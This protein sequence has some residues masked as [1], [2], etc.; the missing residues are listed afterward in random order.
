MYTDFHERFL[1]K[2]TAMDMLS[3]FA[4]FIDRDQ[5][6]IVTGEQL[7]IDASRRRSVVHSLLENDFLEATPM[8]QDGYIVTNKAF[9]DC[10]QAPYEGE[11]NI[12]TPDK[13][14]AKWLSGPMM[15]R[16]IADLVSNKAAIRDA[17]TG[18]GKVVVSTF[19]AR[20]EAERMF[21]VGL[22]ENLGQIARTVTGMSV[23]FSECLKVPPNSLT[24]ANIQ[25]Q[26]CDL[27]NA[28]VKEIER[29]KR[30]NDAIVVFG[31]E[32]EK[33]G[34]WDE[35]IRL[36]KESSKTMSGATTQRRP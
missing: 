21:D 23:A 29:L 35:F 19:D 31:Y 8:G 12:G 18:R 6:L 14:L 26:I 11:L 25:D 34:G 20:S 4:G 16:A 36:A 27:H 28:Q 10:D 32:V 5:A 30:T 17:S 22:A 1:S 15:K 7:E 33:L 13:P 3:K 24:A 9:A 2:Q